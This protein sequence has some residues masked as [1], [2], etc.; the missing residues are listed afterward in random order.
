M[1]EILKLHARSRVGLAALMS[2]LADALNTHIQHAMSTHSTHHHGPLTDVHT[3]KR[4]RLATQQHT[5]QASGQGGGQAT[6]KATG[7]ATGH[8][9][10]SVVELDVPWD[11]IVSNALSNHREVFGDLEVTPQRLFLALLSLAHRTNV[12]AATAAAAAATEVDSGVGDR[13]AAATAKQQVWWLAEWLVRAA[14]VSPCICSRVY[15][16]VWARRMPFFVPFIPCIG[17]HTCVQHTGVNITHIQTVNEQNTFAMILHVQAL[18]LNTTIHLCSP[19]EDD[20]LCNDAPSDACGDQ[21]DASDRARA[22]W[23]SGLT[24]RI[25]RSL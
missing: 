21:G 16:V 23:R 18:L 24:L 19:T 15:C 14:H 11:A 9:S 1:Q 17:G 2:H 7:Q 13:A 6:N 8:T 12:A 25:R 22:Q 10:T 5:G 3:A 4:Q 20:D